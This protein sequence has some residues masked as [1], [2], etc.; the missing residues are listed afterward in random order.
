MDGGHRASPD[1]RAQLLT[2]PRTLDRALPAAYDADMNASP[3]R[4][5]REACLAEALDIID[6]AGLEQLSLREVARRLNVSHQAPYRHFPS[7][8]HLLAEV[9]ARAFDAFAQH[10]DATHQGHDPDI[11]LG[12]MGRAYLAFAMSHP[13][14][15]RLMFGTPL[16]SSDEHPDMM[17]K[18]KH[19]FSLLTE[20]LKKA[21]V[22]HGSPWTEEGIQLDALFIW[23]GLHGLSGILS[24]SATAT[25]GLPQAVMDASAA[26]LLRRFSDAMEHRPPGQNAAPHM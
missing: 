10:L 12:S 18:A 9:V 20:G 6:S 8:D 1:E 21:A 22:K 19:A 7:R 5:L 14:Q 23:S 3:R 15:Y 11:D 17:G 26:H 2:E 4:D 24:S 13:L 16:P 25:L